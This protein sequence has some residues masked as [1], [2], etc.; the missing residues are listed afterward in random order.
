M[1]KRITVCRAKFIN[2][3]KKVYV[4]FRVPD[5]DKLFL[6]GLNLNLSRSISHPRDI[7][8]TKFVSETSRLG[9][10]ARYTPLAN[11]LHCD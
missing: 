7:F 8:V 11:L 2:D 3:S 9:E 6:F 4:P 10:A 5:S 1:Q